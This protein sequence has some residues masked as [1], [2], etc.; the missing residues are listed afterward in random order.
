ML[1]LT[2]IGAFINDSFHI[3]VSMTTPVITIVVIAVS[4]IILIVVVVVT[5]AAV[6]VV[7]TIVWIFIGSSYNRG[8]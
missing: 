3:T 4:I 6:V 7:G 2:I 5:A 1:V 8:W